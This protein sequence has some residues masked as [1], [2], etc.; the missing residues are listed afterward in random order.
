MVFALVLII[1]GLGSLAIQLLETQLD[2]GGWVVL[3]IGLA[4]VGAF[5][6]SRRYGFLIPGGIMTGL[7]AGIV[8]E[9][10]VTL[11]GEQSGGVI[12]LGLGLGFA[13]IWAIGA[14]LKV[15][16]NHPWPL[17]PGFILGAVGVALLIGGTAVDMLN[18]WGVAVIALGIFLLWRAWMDARPQP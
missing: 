9:Q 18:Y 8:I 6:Y 12:V 14:A 13:A 5:V 4:F 2:V 1:V 16:G 11:T 10:A 7:G 15:A 3:I 17:V